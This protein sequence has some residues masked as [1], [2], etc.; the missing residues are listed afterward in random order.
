MSRDGKIHWGSLR[1]SITPSKLAPFN[2]KDR[3]LLKFQR[4]EIHE[5][6]LRTLCLL[7]LITSN[8][9]AFE[10]HSVHIIYKSVKPCMIKNTFIYGLGII[11]TGRKRYA[12]TSYF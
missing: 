9:Q 6:R 10:V 8:S 4:I 1:L 12:G 5:K 11:D 2:S 3:V 7:Y